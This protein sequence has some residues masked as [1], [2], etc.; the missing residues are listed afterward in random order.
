MVGLSPRDMLTTLEVTV[1][2][3]TASV[4]EVSEERAAYLSSQLL[5]LVMLVSCS[6]PFESIT[7]LRI[8]DF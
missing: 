5:R 6:L 3:V 4:L 1:L 7:N 8:L 2:E